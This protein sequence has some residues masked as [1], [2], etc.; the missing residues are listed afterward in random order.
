MRGQGN[1]LMVMSQEFCNAYTNVICCI[2]EEG[3]DDWTKGSLA[4]LER[5]R[6]GG[7]EWWEA[8]SG[9]RKNQGQSERIA[10][11]QQCNPKI[12]CKP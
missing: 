3:G 7:S 1:W 11:V 12:S 9:K 2:K 4:S 8:E 5:R 10:M 6:G